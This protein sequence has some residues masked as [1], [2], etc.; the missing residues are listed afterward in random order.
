M[1]QS[2]VPVPKLLISYRATPHPVSG[3][4]PTALLFSHKIRMKVPHVESTQ[5]NQDDKEI[6]SQRHKYQAQ[7]VYDV[8]FVFQ[9]RV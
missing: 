9:W 7:I 2:V 3:K 8:V 4:S 6:C 5:S 1:E